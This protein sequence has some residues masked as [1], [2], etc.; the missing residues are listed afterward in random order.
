[1]YSSFNNN[2]SSNQNESGNT[3]D[4]NDTSNSGEMKKDQWK[5]EEDIIDNIEE[6]VKAQLEN[7]LQKNIDNIPKGDQ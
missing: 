1:M 4:K 7:F 5:I 6:Y 2:L 3:K